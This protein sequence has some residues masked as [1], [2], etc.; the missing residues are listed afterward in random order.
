[1]N[2]TFLGLSKKEDEVYAALL[3]L[4]EV[5]AK[6]LS[7]ETGLDRTS[8]YDIIEGLA[9]KNLAFKK[10]K[11]KI[12]HFAPHDPRNVLLELKR[13]EAQFKE[14]LPDLTQQF[15]TATRPSSV[16]VHEG[17]DAL[18]KLY[19]SLLSIK[20]LSHYDIIC[21]EKDWLQMNPRYFQR[22]KKRRAEKGIRTRLI[23]EH[24][25][26]A[27]QRKSEEVDTLSETK[28]LPPAFSSLTFSAGCY[29]LPDRVIFI[30][31]RKEHAATEIL[32]EETV[33][34]MQTLFNCI[35]KMIS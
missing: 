29:I 30:S 25:P 5:T 26:V 7:A 31:Y 9:Q 35:W 20:K 24:S 16:R 18:L 27:E 28:L 19:E 8:I 10:E 17:E 6:E 4:G 15:N 12:L 3:R 23:M 13:K 33:A 34:F 2:L 22:Y 14:L 11:G 32:S 21:S 1:M